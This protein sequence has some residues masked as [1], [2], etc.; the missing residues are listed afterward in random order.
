MKP[1]KVVMS[2]FG[3][4]AEKV[5]V[6]LQGFGD[7]G[8]FLI[9]GDTGAGKTTLFDAVAFALFDGASGSVR[10]V[11]TLRSDFASPET[12]T[13]VEVEFSHKGQHYNVTRN[14]RYE[15][16][17]KS[18]IG[19]T[20][21]NADATLLMPNGDVVTGNSKVTE[22]ITQLLGIDFKQFKQIAM[23]AQGEFL[24]LLL[25]E[26]N[27]RAGIF[28]K[29]FNTD[30]Y[31]TIQDELKRK[32]R[33][34]K[35][36]SEDKI[37]SILQYLDGIQYRT[38]L[39][40]KAKDQVA[41]AEADQT[42]FDLLPYR[43]VSELLS[44]RN[45]HNTERILGLLDVVNT[46]EKEYYAQIREQSATLSKAMLT[47]AAELT[48]A[49]YINKSFTELESARIAMAA[50]LQ[51]KPQITQDEA[52]VQAA[53]KALHTVKPVEDAYR[54]EQ[55]AVADLKQQMT[56]V[57]EAITQLKPETE[58][59]HTQ[60]LSEQQ[61]EPLRYNLA[62]EISQISKDLPQY[63]K[64]EDLKHQLLQMH[65]DLG[66]VDHALADLKITKE[67]AGSRLESL[68]QEADSLSNCET[69]LLECTNRITLLDTRENDLNRLSGNIGMIRRLEDE[70]ST[71][72]K[73]YVL[74]ENTYQ[75]INHEY[76]RKE[77]AFWREQAGIIAQT[78][79]E[80]SPCPVCGSCEHPFKA[81]PTADAPNEAELH[82][83]KKDKEQKQLLLQQAGEKCGSKRTQIETSKGHL[84]QSARSLFTDKTGSMS[85]NS[86]DLSDLSDLSHLHDLSLMVNVVNDEISAIRTQKEEQIATHAS[87]TVQDKRRRECLEQILTLEEQLKQTD[88]A[89]AQ[90]TLQSG[91]LA[92]RIS[93][94]NSKIEEMQEHLAFP[95]ADMAKQAFSDLSA[96]L[97]ALKAALQKSE[98]DYHAAKEQLDK[99]RTLAHDQE[100]RMTLLTGE[101]EKALALY[102]SRYREAGFA[103]EDAYRA[104]LMTETELQELKNRITAYDAA[105][106]VSD[107]DITRLLGETKDKEP[108][109]TARIIAMQ[110]RMQQEKEDCEQAMQSAGIRLQT[111]EAIVRTVTEADKVRKQLEN[112]YLVISTLAKTANGE[113]A[114]KQKLAFEQFVQASYFNQI[115]AEANKRL[116]VMSNQRY[117]LLRREYAA[118]NRSQSGLDLDV[119]DNY[120]GKIRTV[121]SL[122]GGESFKASLALA[123]GLSDV[124]QSCAGGV[125]I[126]TMFID[127][128]FGALDSESLEQAIT[129]LNT[130]TTGNRLVGIISHVAELKERIDKKIVIKK[131]MAGSTIE[132]QPA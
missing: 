118:D 80:G 35:K 88:E 2:A 101:C 123:L 61:K 46:Q 47:K 7:Q 124:I 74:T 113:L 10:T 21:E 6:P 48:E 78:L 131:G 34:L 72:Q 11:D 25:A 26:S 50:L 4:Y 33:D 81:I 67:K 18:G 122:S 73:K 95:S 13:Y 107:G 91:E 66:T 44:V 57:L 105:Y 43:E 116:S 120:T 87:L 77:T 110:N 27:E 58:K 90:K 117:E 92:V 71:L 69:L 103:D 127:E 53:E 59:I 121:K 84:F 30:I 42:D 15:R 129:V 28:R 24:K 45:I 111:N 119:L 9:T 114:G 89:L 23:I 83:M 100:E 54:R 55:N 102:I 38:D 65:N 8:L 97:H 60:W 99:N 70:F 39:D 109:D 64:M 63:G 22:K 52:R 75:E 37:Q 12:K 104:A 96:Q 93:A 98:N 79:Q 49:E 1:L 85:F 40:E 86:S 68:R 17:K 112:D 106:Q 5:E 51:R 130:L 94:R 108:R 16:P 3:P 32:E 76:S 62:S 19:F 41:A 56:A 36:Q 31:L 125:E 29:V 115:I 128:G 126:D 82:E 20:S 14:P 132:L